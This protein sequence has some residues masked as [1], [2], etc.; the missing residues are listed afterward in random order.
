MKR[1]SPHKSTSNE[2][3]LPL[4]RNFSRGPSLW[5]SSVHQSNWRVRYRVITQVWEARLQEHNMDSLCP[6]RFDPQVSKQMS[7]PPS[8]ASDSELSA[9]SRLGHAPHFCRHRT[10]PKAL[11]TPY[12]I[13]PGPGDCRTCMQSS[14]RHS[15]Y[16]QMPHRPGAAGS[17][18]ISTRP[19]RRLAIALNQNLH[20]CGGRRKQVPPYTG[21]DLSWAQGG[22]L[23]SQ[24]RSSIPQQA[25]PNTCCYTCGN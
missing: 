11:G 21:S 3:F 8:R 2:S 7:G 16:P 12:S 6:P 10:E 24:L 18:D 22:T 14:R 19:S 5:R 17:P 20:F 4:V 25:L 9:S 1:R 13:R 23:G 15:R